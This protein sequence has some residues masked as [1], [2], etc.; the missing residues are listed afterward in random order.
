MPR[1][2]DR[3]ATS[4]QSPSGDA[5]ARRRPRASAS[6]LIADVGDIG[7]LV[8]CDVN[9]ATALQTLLPLLPGHP[10]PASVQLTIDA[11]GPSVPARPPDESGADLVAWR[12]DGSIAFRHESGATACVQGDRAS[13]GSLPTHGARRL[14]PLAL[15]QLLG[16]HDRFVLHGAGLVRDG[17]AY[18]ALG[19]TGSGKST[20]SL[21]ALTGGWQVLADD[22]VV[23]REG[24]NRVEVAGIPRTV[25]VSEALVATTGERGLMAGA[26]PVAD[27]SRRRCEL[28]PDVLTPGWWPVAGCLLLGHSTR[29][30]GELDRVSG[31]ETLAHV[32]DAFSS[33]GEI[34]L[35]RRFFPH[36][37]ALSR[38]P[39]W[40]LRHGVRPAQRLAAARA[41][42]DGVVAAP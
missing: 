12:E 11:P 21:A 9:G 16:R 20:L 37:A 26:R 17:T 5:A 39:G 32:V 13:V 29:P 8:R 4:S 33:A 38:C 10:G 34:E 15:T 30:P 1:P 25:V 7:V 6:G 24:S 14:L 22:L 23:I 36:A 35:V 2:I 40:A 27:D 31:H 28:P 3:P 42:L 18:L 19:D 41:L